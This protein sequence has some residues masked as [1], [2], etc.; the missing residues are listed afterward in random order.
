MQRQT[1][2]RPQVPE[3]VSP[4]PVLQSLNFSSGHMHTAPVANNSR[5]RDVPGLG[6][7]QLSLVTMQ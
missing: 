2:D 3:A 5:E 1:Q 7:L 4:Y 6:T